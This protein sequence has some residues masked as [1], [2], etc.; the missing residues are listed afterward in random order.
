MT[1]KWK[2]LVT[3]ALASLS[4]SER[5]ESIAYIEQRVIPAGEVLSWPGITQ[6]F[7]EAVVIAFI[8][9][10]PEFNWTHRGRYI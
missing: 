8:D 5:E 10:E 7:N 2:K 3:S 4:D 6:S 1:V 9:L